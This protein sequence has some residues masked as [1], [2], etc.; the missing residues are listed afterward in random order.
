MVKRV[1]EYYVF[2]TWCIIAAIIM[3]VSSTLVFQ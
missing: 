1:A 2:L 3:F